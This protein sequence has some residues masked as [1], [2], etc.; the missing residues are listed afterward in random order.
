MVE[1]A[2]TALQAA[3]CCSLGEEEDSVGAT[4]LGRVAS[5]YYLQHAT[6]EV[7][8]RSLQPDMQLPQVLQ[9]MCSVA[10][11]D[12]L[13]VRHNEDKLNAAMI[14]SSRFPPDPRTADDPH[15]KASLLLQAHLSR[16]ALPI[17]DYV[18]DTKGVLDNSARILQA[19]L[20][21]A[22]EAGWLGTALA[23]VQLMQSLTQS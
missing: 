5:F 8:S 18:T 9:V 20:D 23:A 15:T 19:L 11:Y 16:S 17:S 1:G 13:P 12:E 10:E 2:L 3:G 14:S 6:M 21:V 22:A 7:F 4:A